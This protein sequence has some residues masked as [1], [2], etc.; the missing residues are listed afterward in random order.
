MLD[1][2]GKQL[3][4][5]D[6]RFDNEAA[7]IKDQKGILIEI[8][9]KLD[10]APAVS[11]GHSSENGINKDFIDIKVKNNGSFEDL[12]AAAMFIETMLATGVIRT[13]LKLGV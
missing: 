1:N 6:V 9:R 13:P 10:D 11:R 5:A 2:P 3:I 12:E 7:F 4:V 8:I